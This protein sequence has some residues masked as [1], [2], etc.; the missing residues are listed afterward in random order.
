L[1]STDDPILT[2]VGCGIGA[3]LC[4]LTVL[5]V[6]ALRSGSPVPEPEDETTLLVYTEEVTPPYEVIDEKKAPEL[7]LH[8]SCL[9]CLIE[10]ACPQRIPIYLVLCILVYFHT[11]LLTRM[12]CDLFELKINKL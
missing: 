2:L 9:A 1:A 12:K 6:H 3:L 4:V 5:L 8:K 11:I 10:H 7:G